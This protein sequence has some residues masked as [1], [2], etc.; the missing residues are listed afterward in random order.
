MYFSKQENKYLFKKKKHTHTQ[1][2][3]LRLASY[4]L[5]RLIYIIRQYSIRHEM[6]FPAN[7]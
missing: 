3:T 4:T 7:F 5:A 1:K 2:D 6:K